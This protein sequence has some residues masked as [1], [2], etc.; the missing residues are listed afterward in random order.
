MGR[1]RSAPLP[2][3]ER[4]SRLKPILLEAVPLKKVGN[5]EQAGICIRGGGTFIL[6][7]NPDEDS[8][9]SIQSHGR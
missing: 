6:S 2:R 4:A 1:R 8:P 3:K 7:F 9:R 5:T